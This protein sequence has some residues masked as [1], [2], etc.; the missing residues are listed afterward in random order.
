MLA[1]ASVSTV[2]ALEPAKDRIVVVMSVDGLAHYYFD[3]PKAEMPN[4]RA[5][6]AEG[7]RAR[8]MECSLPTV[9]WPNHTTLVTGVAPAKHGVLGNSYFDRAEQKSV[10]LILDPIYEK[11]ELVKTPTAYDVAHRAGLKTAAILWP[12]SRGAKTLDWTVPDAG[13]NAMWEKSGTPELLKE[14]REAGIPVDQ[15]EA[16]VKSGDGVS[17]DRMYTQMFDLV[18]QKHRPNLAYLHI[19]DV[20]HMEHVKG[21]QSPEAYAAVK[22]ADEHVG[23]VWTELKKDFAGKATFIVTAD[24]GFF[25][26]QQ[27]IQPNV[28]L[29]K[30]GL[31]TAVGGKI[32]GGR[33]RSYSQGGAAFIYVLDQAHRDELIQQAADLL[34]GVEGIS[35]VIRPSEFA[36]HGLAS[37]QKDARIGDLVITAKSGYMFSDVAGGDDVV[38]PK[39]EAVRGAHGYDPVEPGMHATFVAWGVGIRPGVVLDD[40]KNM[41]VAPTTAALLGLE[42]PG[43]DGHVLDAILQK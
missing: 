9:T 3:D 18:L 29:A 1:V 16:W 24:H 32:T 34:K 28:L 42:I 12:A 39:F 14:A 36:A 20:D 40:I 6:A 11:E 37:P 7:A 22:Q 30:S 15:Q 35:L 2:H 25:P 21:P 10:G 43:V 5:L 26:Y 4:I 41:D 19:I 17:R 27:F 13:T 8:R 23:E 31:L 33:V 38:T